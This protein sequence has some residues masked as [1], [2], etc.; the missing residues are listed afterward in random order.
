MALAFFLPK[1]N[2]EIQIIEASPRLGGRIQ[3]SLGKL[4]TPLELGA[5]WFSDAHQNLLRLLEEL[6]LEKYPQFSL[7]KS[8]FNA[9]YIH[10]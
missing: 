1:E 5:T 10:R 2:L 4:D 6:G 7:G 3:T 9:C 8:I